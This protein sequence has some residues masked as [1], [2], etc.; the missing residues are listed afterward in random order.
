M[1]QPYLVFR[2]YAPMASWG[3]PAVGQDRHSAISPTRSALLGLLGAALGIKR[4]EQLSLL[5]LQQSVNFAVKQIV[6]SSLLRDFHT[7]QVPK[8]KRKRVFHT[9]REELQVTELETILSNRYYRCDGL[10]II[11]V[12]LTPQSKYTLEQLKLALEKPKFTLYLGRKSCP[13]TAPLLPEI[14]KSVALKTALDKNFPALTAVRSRDG[15]YI[16]CNELLWLDR[17]HQQESTYFWQGDKNALSSSLT[18]NVVSTTYPWDEPLDRKR[19][20]FTQRTLHQC[21][22][23]SQEKE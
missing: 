13:L 4:D 8:A 22:L 18:E 17:Y 3:E 12:S 5:A 7:I 1:Q 11:A 14:I 9:R 21:T 19:W 16:E 6:S 20:Q 10:W 2:L 23:K 15:K